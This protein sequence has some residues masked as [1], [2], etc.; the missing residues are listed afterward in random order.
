LLDPSQRAR[1]GE[2]VGGTQTPP[3]ALANVTPCA[4][5]I[6]KL[7]VRSR[8]GTELTAGV[9]LLCRSQKSTRGEDLIGIAHG[10][11][12]KTQAPPDES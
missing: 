10:S 1:H 2:P 9:T 6:L 11:T 7:Q 3:R 5:D 8:A 12:W 4:F